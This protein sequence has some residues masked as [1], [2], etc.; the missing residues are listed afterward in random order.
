MGGGPPLPFDFWFHDWLNRNPAYYT[1][2]LHCWHRW[3]EVPVSLGQRMQ[4]Q[5]SSSIHGMGKIDLLEPTKETV[6]G[7][8]PALLPH[9]RSP[10]NRPGGESR[11]PVL[12]AGA[13]AILLCA[14]NGHVVL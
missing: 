10:I 12:G 8:F 6:K 11:E 2:L 4:S 14:E 3:P 5:L 1:T 13:L 9:T 7:R